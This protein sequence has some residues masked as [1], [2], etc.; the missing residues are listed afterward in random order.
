MFSQWGSGDL[1]VE[2][3]AAAVDRLEGN[4]AR[5]CLAVEDIEDVGHQIIHRQ[6]DV[7]VEKWLAD[8]FVAT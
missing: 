6:A 7:E 5:T 3:L 8:H 1:A 4:L 2:R